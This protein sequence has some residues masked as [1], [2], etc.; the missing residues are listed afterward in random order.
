M[1]ISQ[2]KEQYKKTLKLA[3][4]VM[5]SYM[6]ISAVQLFDNAM[7]GRLGALPLAA[8]SFG[9]TVFFLFFIL[10]TGIS[11][12][13]TP[14]VGEQ[15]AQGHYRAAGAYFQNSLLLYTV[16]GLVGFAL[17]WSTIPLL[18]HLGQPTE[19]VDMCIPYY[20]YLVWSTIPYMIFCS[21][22]RFLEGI[23][24]TTTNMVIITTSNLVN[25]F[26]NWLL[27]YGN[28]GFPAMGAAGAGMGTLISRICM[29]LLA[30]AYFTLKPRFRR[31]F[32][33][34]RWSNFGLKRIG[35]LLS[36][37]FPISLQMFMEGSAFAI[38]AIMMGWM[39]TVAI[40]SHQIANVVSSFTFMIVL[41]ISAAATI[42]VSHAYGR[43]QF[44]LLKR[45]A[46][47]SQ[48]L[49]LIWN[50]FAATMFIIFRYQIASIFTSDPEVL[51]LAAR[52]MIYV[53]AFQFADGLQSVMVGVLRGIQ[54]VK[55]VMLIAFISYIVINLPV[56]YL[57]AFKLDVG[58]G[59]LWIGFI[60][61]LYVAAGL[62]YMRF[63]RQLART[64]R[65]R[66]ESGRRVS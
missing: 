41:G 11:M 14:L 13:L 65:Q 39:G 23:G 55:S 3:A 61:G 33:Y 37:G 35:K 24:N 51:E 8:V 42:R 38:S 16:I 15:Y 40:A 29:P 62:L 53:A 22:E 45:A 59:G 66:I 57:I 32:R 31:Y 49:T 1:N 58:P 43:G 2:Y 46:T 4:P 64:R 12:A 18:Y 44:T 27:I 36:V 17:Q 7:V 26:C 63:G 50:T 28:W 48:H 56:G 47:A 20:K 52:L 21:G 9:G 19:V 60:F 10:A 6:G 34:F 25:I 54:D 30:T 5:L